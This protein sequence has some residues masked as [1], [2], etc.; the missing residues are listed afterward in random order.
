VKRL[1]EGQAHRRFIVAAGREGAVSA[2]ARTM[3]SGKTCKQVGE[4]DVVERRARPCKLLTP[5]GRRLE[6]LSRRVAAELIVRRA[7][8][9]ILEPVS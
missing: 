9:G 4:I 8:L 2:R 3:A 7:L 6:V 5:V 1:V